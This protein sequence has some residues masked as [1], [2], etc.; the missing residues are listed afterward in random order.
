MWTIVNYALLSAPGAAVLLLIIARLI[1]NDKLDTF[2]FKCG[3]LLT[4]YGKS[5]LGKAFWEKIEDFIEN[6]FQVFFCAFQRGLHSDDNGEV[7]KEDK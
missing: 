7:K 1:P 6:S 5:K 4:L 3:C 2:G